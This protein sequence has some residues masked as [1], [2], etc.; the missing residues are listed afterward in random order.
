M[1]PAERTYFDN[2]PQQHAF[3]FQ[4]AC[5]HP[6]RPL[7]GCCTEIIGH[8]N[9]SS[10]QNVQK[11]LAACAVVLHASEDVPLHLANRSANLSRMKE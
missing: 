4:H 11:S 10:L 1:S 6:H 5:R 7:L 2:R 8:V 3:A 9:L